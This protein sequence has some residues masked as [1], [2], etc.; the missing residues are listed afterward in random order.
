LFSRAQSG[1]KSNTS[2]IKICTHLL[3]FTDTLLRTTSL[4]AG[5]Q[6]KHESHTYAPIA[7]D[8]IRRSRYRYKD[9]ETEFQN[10]S[11]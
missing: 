5:K 4:D 1:Y 8:S 3:I 11:H 2:E 7:P 10:D 6:C 9:T